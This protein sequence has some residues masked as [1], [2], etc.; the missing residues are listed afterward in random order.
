M[1]DRMSAILRAL[2]VALCCFGVVC[3]L[4]PRPMAALAQTTIP[5]ECLDDQGRSLVPGQPGAWLLVLNFNHKLNAEYTTGCL[6]TLGVGNP[7]PTYQLV[8]C[9]LFNNSQQAQV[10]AGSA[11]FDGKFWIECPTVPT[12]SALTKF[13]MQAHARFAQPGLYTIVD[14]PNVAMRATIDVD[15]RITLESRYGV[16]MFRHTDPTTVA[17]QRDLLLLS[18]LHQKHGTHAVNGT[19]LSPQVPVNAFDFKAKPLRISG[20]GQYWSISELL[21][22]PAGVCCTRS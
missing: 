4:S 22:D 3:W 20:A 2:W 18:D 5:A 1:P 21:I 8:K 10:G 9:P 17:H 16:D 14:H 19:Y 11:N 15:W 13:N 7:Q 12:L 6:I